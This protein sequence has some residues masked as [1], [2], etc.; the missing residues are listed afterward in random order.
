MTM[1]W[2]GRSSGQPWKAR[3][4]GQTAISASPFGE[5]TATSVNFMEIEEALEPEPVLVV[6]DPELEA[7]TI[8]VPAGKGTAQLDMFGGL[9]NIG[10]LPRS[11]KGKW[12]WPPEGSRRGLG[13]AW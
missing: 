12:Y 4:S 9:V 7:M 10:A 1:T 2:N 5:P 6:D 11:G 13:E 3:E 8:P